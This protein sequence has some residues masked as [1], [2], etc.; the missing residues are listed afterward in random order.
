MNGFPKNVTQVAV[1]AGCPGIHPDTFVLQVNSQ[2][3]DVDCP[4]LADSAVIS[5]VSW[6]STKLAKP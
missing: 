2:F 4:S 3:T 1:V 5:N 6:P